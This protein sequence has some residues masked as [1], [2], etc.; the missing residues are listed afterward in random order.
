MDRS[1]ARANTVALQISLQTASHV[2]HIPRKPRQSRLDDDRRF[3]R[4]PRLPRGETTS[5]PRTPGRDRSRPPKKARRITR[6]TPPTEVVETTPTVIPQHSA[7]KRWLRQAISEESDSPNADAFVAESP[8]NEIVTPLKKRRLARESLSCEPNNIVPCHD[9]ASPNLT[10]EDSPVKDDGGLVRQYNVR[11]IMEGVY[12]RDR[13]RSDSGQG[14][15]DQCHPDHDVLNVNMAHT[16][17]EHIRRIIGVPTPEDELP[18]PAA[19]KPDLANNNNVE[20]DDPHYDKAVPMDIDTTLT[21]Q[22]KL[23]SG[24]PANCDIKGVDLLNDKQNSSRSADTSGNSSPQRDEMDDIQKKIHSFHTENILI[25]KSRNKKPPKEKR[26][27]VNLNFDL[28]MV[29]DQISIQLRTE[30]ESSKSPEI[31]GDIHDDISNS[32]LPAPE[33]IPLPDDPGPIPPLEAIPLPEEPMRPIKKQFT[34]NMKN[35][36]LV[37]N[38]VMHDSFTIGDSMALPAPENIPL[39]EDQGP[40]SVIPPLETIPLPEEPRRPLKARVKQMIEKEEKEALSNDTDSKSS[41]VNGEVHSEVESIPLP[42]DIPSLEAIPL[43]EEPMEPVRVPA[44]PS[45]KPEEKTL[46]PKD[47]PSVLESPL[48]FSSRFSSTG[49]FSGIF[50]N[51]SQPYDAPAADPV[52][53]II[54]SAIDRTTSLDNSIFDKDS[55]TGVDELKSVQEILTRVSNMDSNNSVLLSGVLQG[56]SGLPGA[57]TPHGLPGPAKPF[58]ARASDPRLNP[59]PQDK[60]KPVRRKLSITEYR[61]RHRGPLPEEAHAEGEPAGPEWS[62]ESS[63]AGSLSPQRLDAAAA[64][65]VDDLEQRLHR[66]LTNTHLPKGVFDAQPTASERQRE[67]LSSRLRREFGLAL[68]E[69]ERHE[70]VTEGAAVLPARR[71]DR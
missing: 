38:G 30:K 12:G 62:S 23:E 31:N 21:P 61:K 70:P 67:N 56:S 6:S 18:A 59:P 71:C 7:K 41:E 29:D 69:D 14:S 25:L 2:R 42:D 17:S 51:F 34:G 5:P 8:P 53:S 58:G 40:L 39:P 27:K 4:G 1:V 10:S 49:L 52:P 3:K 15:D 36:K 64:A 28:N 33:N 26:K 65:A 45:S 68:P 60:P 32:A 24:E 11:G 66:E 47:K 20:P 48:P 54:K 13:T 9:E 35:S 22:P 19:A 37:I 43:P 63:G 44:S 57:T 16:T 50:S 55:I 46:P